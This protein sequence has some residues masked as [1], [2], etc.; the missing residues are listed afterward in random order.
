MQDVQLYINEEK[1]LSGT[2]TYS[3]SYNISDNTKN[4]YE[5]DWVVGAVIT[6]IASGETANIVSIYSQVTIVIDKLASTFGYGSYS[7]S[8]K[9]PKRLDLFKD[10]TISLTQTIKNIKDISKIQTDFSQKFTVPASK[11]NNKIFKHYYNSSVSDGFDARMLKGSTIKLNGADFKEGKMRLLGIKMKDN[12]PYAYNV[13]FV[14]NTVSL[15]DMFSDDEISELPYLDVFNHNYTYNNILQYMQVGYNFTGSGN[16][17]ADH[18]D[19]M[20]PF[21][22][23]D[24]R[25]Y[26]D[27]G[28]HSNHDEIEGVRN[29]YNHDPS[30]TNNHA[31]YHSLSMYD[32]K[33]AIKV[34]YVLKAIEAKYGFT[35][36]T[37]FFSQTSEVFEKLYM[38]CNRESGSLVNL[39]DETSGE[40]KFEDLTKASGTEVREENN[41]SF[42]LYTSSPSGGRTTYTKLRYQATIGVVGTGGYDFRLYDAETEELYAEVL[43]QTGSL[44]FDITFSA[45]RNQTKVIKPKVELKTKAGITS[46]SLGSVTL[47]KIEKLTL[48]GS[49]TTT[50]GSYY[51]TSVTLGN[52]LDF[53]NKLLPKIKVLDFM[54]GLFNMFNLVAYFEGTE[55][56]VKT[57]DD[58]YLTSSHNEYVIDKYVDS[59]SSQV[60]RSDIYS[61]INYEF[62]KPKT[63]FVIKSNEATGDE[64]GNERF[65][66]E[67][68]NVFDG[69]KYDVKVKFGN[70]IYEDLIDLDDNTSSGILWSY[71]VDKDENPTVQAPTLFFNE[72]TTLPSDIY[73]TDKPFGET[74]NGFSID[75]MGF[76]QTPRSYY[77]ITELVNGSP[78]T[79]PYSINF[80]SEYAAFG[81]FV[82]DN[83][84]FK[85]YHENFIQN[86]YAQNARIVKI[87]AHLPLRVLLK[88]K[89]NDRFIIG[90]KKYL[91]NSAK[92]NLQTGKTE[93]ELLTDNYI[94]E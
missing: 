41:T 8:K 16:S 42:E 67:G 82:I 32:F 49:E 17:S 75:E 77:A 48:Q 2:I 15:K 33:P 51:G 68:D 3:T 78:V 39:I 50:S 1:S 26:Y 89:L 37:D 9:D 43:N 83:G 80:G 64:Y 22:S 13:G 57:L 30:T 55:L 21:I 27:S 72:K 87:S 91:I 54:K 79:T 10:E 88:Y 20:Y 14:G 52:G 44:P 38:W 25:Y 28:Q 93:L 4:F 19:M 76:L 94:E 71:S 56:V 36:S 81:N 70:M 60:N 18:P 45:P 6:N 35:F 53:R 23:A 90:G 62:E 69:G 84:L 59:S 24:S 74:G 58:Y 86:I 92:T 47:T 34:Y 66:S 31:D 61:E 73:F 85:E 11:N 65:K 29:I 5:N 40:I 46:F 63:I 12:K 7:I